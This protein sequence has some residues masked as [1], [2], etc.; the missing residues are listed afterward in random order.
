MRWRHLPALAPWLWRLVRSGTAGHMEAAAAAL[1]GLHAPAL[2]LYR[3]LARDA[4]V[5]EL[6]RD[7][8]YL[9]VFRA[10]RA[11]RISEAGWRLRA[12]RG[13]RLEVL[14]GGAIRELE[15]DLSEAYVQAVLI[16]DQGYCANPG[17][18]V[19]ALAT[20]FA[21]EGGTVLR[22]EVTGLTTTETRVSAVRTS[23]RAIECAAV[24][25]AAGAW[26]TR[27]TRMLGLHL[28]LE[29]ERGYHVVLSEP[30]V[31]ITRTIMETAG[32]FIAT[33]METGLRFAGT[34]EL[35]TVDAPPDYRRADAI[36]R[37]ARRMFPG[38]RGEPA[39]RW[40]GPR[41]SLP[42][43]LPVIDRAPRHENVYLA[44][45]HAHTGM[46]GGPGTGRIV[47]GMVCDQPVNI[48]LRPFRAGRFS[49]V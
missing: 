10:A 9:H 26:S 17:R 49:R 22:A 13:A 41:P 19:K 5:A 47:A 45:G 36:L 11:D 7:C 8:G 27:V 20:H 37:M 24:V 38:L 33:P 2:G 25:I 48:D 40:M 23:T 12:E 18:L 14:D 42:D 31:S 6:V 46:V 28:P 30:G 29:A 3:E 32:K 39:S 21:G 34:V 35:A 15:P 1:G 4:G 44:F 43:G 16:H